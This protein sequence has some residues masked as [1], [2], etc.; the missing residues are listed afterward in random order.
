MSATQP[1]R[2]VFVQPMHALQNFK[3]AAYGK[4]DATGK[5]LLEEADSSTGVAQAN[6]AGF[7]Q[8]ET[9]HSIL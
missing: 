1:R 6:V 8:K 3:S 7:S 5:F 4:K 9:L 2:V